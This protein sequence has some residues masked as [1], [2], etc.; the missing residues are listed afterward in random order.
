[1]K[2]NAIL[3]RGAKKDFWD[4]AEL[5]N[6]FTLDEIIQFHKQK[7]PTQMLLISIPAALT[8]FA[9]AE[10]SEDPVSLKGQSWEETK[11]IIQGK[12]REYLS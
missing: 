2:I 11:R 1:M 12:V 9:D 6:V 3:G 8:Y 5:L 10:E 4:L 7:F